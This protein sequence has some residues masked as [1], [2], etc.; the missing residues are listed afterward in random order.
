MSVRAPLGSPSTPSSVALG[1][2]AKAS[3]VGAKM[4]KGPGPLRVSTSPAAFTAVTRVDRAGLLLAAV[5]AGSA[6]MPENEPA[7]EDGTAAQPGPKLALLRVADPA[8][9][10]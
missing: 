2:L 7:P 9:P 1:I 5:A 4:V 8:A 3:L 6:A 10:M